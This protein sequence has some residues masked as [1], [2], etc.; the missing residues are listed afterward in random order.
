MVCAWVPFAPERAEHLQPGAFAPFGLGTHRCLGSNFAEV[1]LTLLTIVHTVELA[2]DPPGYARE[3][4]HTPAPQPAWSF[5]FR[6]LRQRQRPH[7]AEPEE[8]GRV[9]RQEVHPARSTPSGEDLL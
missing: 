9:S 8:T 1:A 3:I 7:G 4:R 6:V 5:K 2:L